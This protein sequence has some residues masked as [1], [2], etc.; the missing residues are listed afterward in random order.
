MLE[1]EQGEMNL[2]LLSDLRRDLSEFCVME[3][4][5]APS[6]P[7]FLAMGRY[8]YIVPHTIWDPWRSSLRNATEHLFEQSGHFPMVEEPRLFAQK[9]GAWLQSL[10]D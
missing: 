6:R 1:F 10:E 9:L 3:K 4:I 5:P 8:D 2:A 7:L